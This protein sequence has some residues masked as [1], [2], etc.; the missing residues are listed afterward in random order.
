MNSV[1]EKP[2]RIASAFSVRSLR[3]LSRIRKNN[4]DARLPSIR[5]KAMAT[6]IFMMSPI[7][8]R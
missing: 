2:T 7:R 8:L 6:T 5:M 3:P 1:M 4:A